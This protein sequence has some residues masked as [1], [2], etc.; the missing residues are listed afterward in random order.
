M[1]ADDLDAV[2]TKARTRYAQLNGWKFS[3]QPFP[4]CR[5]WSRCDQEPIINTT[6]DH[7]E[8]FR[9]DRQPVAMVVHNY[10]HRALD[11]DGHGRLRLHR[12]PDAKAAS[13]YLPGGT[14]AVCITGVEVERVVWLP[15]AEM[16][17]I[18]ERV[19]EVR[20]DAADA[21]R[22]RMRS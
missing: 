7:P 1:S 21:A 14:N 4:L 18:A 12:P 6:L 3:R 15:P 9:M 20:R 11:F 2:L 16:A 13:W 5:L 22:A 8:F 10:D 17:V 19:L